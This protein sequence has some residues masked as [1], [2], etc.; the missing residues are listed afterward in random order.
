M[1]LINCEINLVLNW[2]KNCIIVS[3]AVA[4]HGA[5]FSKTDTKRYVPVVTLSIQDNTKLPKQIKTGFKR[6]INWNK[7]QSIK[8]IERPNEYLN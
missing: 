1:S 6:T 5:I 8:S 4:N 3:T 7:H 2:F